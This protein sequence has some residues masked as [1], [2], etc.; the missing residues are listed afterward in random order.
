MTEPRDGDTPTPEATAEPE[1][2][3]AT[4]ELSSS[5]LEPLEVAPP[6]PPPAPAVSPRPRSPSTPRRLKKTLEGPGVVL[7]G[8]SAG[9]R[10]PSAPPRGSTPPSPPLPDE[11]EEAEDASPEP[12]SPDDL[13]RLVGL[14][15][16]ELDRAPSPGRAARLYLELARIAE[17]HR[18]DDERAAEHYQSALHLASDL[19]VAIRGARRVQARLGRF[20]ALPHLFDA[21]LRLTREPAARARLLMAKGRVL[22]DRL[23]QPPAALDAYR[24]ALELDPSNLTVLKAIERT[25][26]RDRRHAGLIETYGKLAAS[27][28]DPSLEAAWTARQARLVAQHQG[29]LGT[30]ATLMGRALEADPHATE[31]LTALSQAL[32]TQRRW[33]ELLPL[34]ERERS[35]VT[36]PAHRLELTLAIA[37]IQERHLGDFGGALRTLAQAATT[38]ADHKVVHRE[39]ARLAELLGQTSALVTALEQLVRLATD[40]EERAAHSHRLAQVFDLR[41]HHHE[42][43]ARWYRDA[44]EHL[45]AHASSAEALALLHERR[46]EWERVVEVLEG[47]ADHLPDDRRRADLYQRTASILEHYLKQ[48]DAAAE[49]HAKALS[50]VPDHEAAFEDLCRLHAAAHRWAAVA[51]LYQRAGERASEGTTAIAWLLRLGAIQEDRLAEPHA[52]LATYD[53]VLERDPSHLGALHAVRRVA[54]GVGFFPRVIDALHREAE[55]I[56]GEERRIELRHEAAVLTADRLIDLPEAIRLLEAI[57]EDTPQHRPSLQTL[58]RLHQQRGAW[59][60]LTEVL[61]RLAELTP[62]GPG[63]AALHH[64]VAVLAEQQRGRPREALASYRKALEADAGHAPSQEAL[65]ALLSRLGEPA[66]LVA[67]LVAREKRTSD[68]AERARLATAAGQLLEDTSSKVGPALRAYERALEALPTHRPALAAR[69][70]LLAREERWQELV[71]VLRA[72]VKAPGQDAVHLGQAALT[73]ALVLAER[74]DA[75][76]PALEALRP[77]FQLRADHPGALLAV[78]EI[79]ARSKDDEGLAA[80]YEKLASITDDVAAKRA[81]LADLARVTAALGRDPTPV[82][83]RLLALAPEDPLALEALS[84]AA[85]ASED[86]ATQL[87]M[88]ARLASTSGDVQVAAFHR[89]QVGELLL[90]EGDATGAVSAF[91]SALDADAQSLAAARGLSRAAMAAADPAALRRAAAAEREITR[92]LDLATELWLRAAALRAGQPEEAALDYAAALDI[93][94]DRRE[95]SEGL[96]QA[97]L[98]TDQADRLV[99]HLERAARATGQPERAS[100]LYRD[101]AAVHADARRDLGAAIATARRALAATPRDHRSKSALATYLERNGNWAEATE[102]LEALVAVETRG[103]AYVDAQL[104]IGHLAETRLQDVDRALRAH[105]AVLSRHEDHPDAL[106]ALVRLER[107]KGRDDEA[108]RLAARLLEVAPDEATQ[109]RALLHVAELASARQ[110]HEEAAAAAL[111]VLRRRGPRSPAAELYRGLLREAPRHASWGAYGRALEEHLEHAKARSLSVS[112]VYRELARLYLEVDNRP[113]RALAVLQEG[114]E[115]A[116]EDEGLSLTLVDHLRRVDA[117]DRALGEL[118]RLLQRDV[119]MPAAWRALADLLRTTQEGGGA[120][121]ALQGLATLGEQTP[122]E[123]QELDVRLPRTGRAPP[124][125]LGP[126]GLA[127]LAEPG[128]V[129]SPIQELVVALADIVPKLVSTDVEP[130]GVFRRDR[131]RAGDP[132]PVRQQLDRLLPIF[133]PVEC[134]LLLAPTVERATLVPSAPPVLLYPERWSQ[135]DEAIVLFE[136]ARSLALIAGQMAVADRLSAP[137]LDAI[138]SGAA[139]HFDSTFA[140][141]RMPSEELDAQ[142]RR[143]ARALPFFN[144]G[145]LQDA[146]TTYSA[147]ATL[148]DVGA[149]QLQVQRLAQRAA[150]LVTDDLPSALHVLGERVGGEG[151]GTDL[152]RFWISDPAFRFRRAQEAALP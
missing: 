134:D 60:D 113:D 124:G 81:A 32:I 137:Q 131:L 87:A 35:L 84:E 72:S 42:R 128:V 112:E 132:H 45:P 82:Y 19:K 80:T 95:A 111:E 150:V 69:E 93:A 12:P 102:V 33:G 114:I 26:R 94:P 97:M 28:S 151:H 147:Q 130:F 13:D 20:P 76:G 11:A 91:A 46:G 100:E 118:R 142:A 67:A 14:L 126:Q 57:L 48:P 38:H 17:I 123:Q 24:A 145:R 18:G 138:L 101:A 110:D 49:R 65:E 149:W 55:L 54:A 141:P 83:K 36:A 8:P 90:A 86:R 15:R 98:A 53:R 139:R 34:L 73:A 56:E 78:E 74:Q 92:D 143:V 37:R 133:G 3:D 146:A 105:R 2:P 135:A 121:V 79:Y 103:A 6:K 44:L 1:R 77:V 63:R 47:H 62:A 52:A 116:P 41:L 40:P 109:T 21:E 10:V 99:E 70:R 64:R 152:V 5:E 85:E 23:R 136:L 4:A 108:L 120:P 30:A 66:E 59:E 22:E 7:Q 107:R 27:V 29:D 9:P 31:A 16:A 106:A 115:H 144:R 43:A 39:Q 125:I 25:Q 50:L 129:G 96:C 140:H 89:S 88:Q 117:H 119:R 61:E 148:P 127:Q 58:V 75:V 104:R 71:E 51:E 122:A 68:P